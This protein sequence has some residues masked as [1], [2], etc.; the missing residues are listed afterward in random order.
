MAS[1]L[2]ACLTS[3]WAFWS[4]RWY[5]A[6]S[7]ICCCA[8]HL[9]AALQR[10]R[11]EPLRGKIELQAE[12]SGIGNQQHDRLVAAD[13]PSAARNRIQ[14]QRKADHQ[15][16]IDAQRG[17]ADRQR[18]NGRGGAKNQQNVEQVE[19]GRAHV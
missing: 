8:S 11:D 7:G 9:R 15:R 3:A 4:V 2:R 14:Q 16:Q 1:M 6:L 12:K 17:I 13:Y 18:M 10:N 19:I 5:R